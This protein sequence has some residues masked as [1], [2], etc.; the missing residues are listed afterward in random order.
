MAGGAFTYIMV[1][2]GEFPAWMTV[3]N[4][5]TE[6]LFGMAVVARSFSS[7]LADLCGKGPNYFRIG[8]TGSST[9][10][11]LDL[12]AMAIV[13]VVSLVFAA[14]GRQG[15]LFISIVSTVKLAVIVFILIVGWTKGDPSNL[16]PF[17]LEGANGIFSAASIFMYA[18]TGF[19]SITNAAEEARNVSSLPWAILGTT[20][21]ST[22]IYMLLA[23]MLCLMVPTSAISS[24]DGISQAFDYVGLHYMPYVVAT[25]AVMGCLTALLVGLYAVSRIIMVVARDWL[26][27]PVFARISARTQT[28]LVAQLTIGGIIALI[29]MLVQGEFLDELVSFGQ[30]FSMWAVVNAQMFRRYYPGIKLRFTRFGAVETMHAKAVSDF[31]P[32]ARLQIGVAARRKLAI[33]HMVLLSVWAFALAVWFVVTEQHGTRSMEVAGCVLFGCLLFLTALSMRLLCPI[34]YEPTQFHVPGILMPWVPTVAIGLIFFGMASI[35]PTGYYKIGVY[36]LAILAIY[37][38]FSLPMSYI[39]HYKLDFVQ[40]EQLKYVGLCVGICP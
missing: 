35:N 27:P 31:V 36:N 15:H 5:F 38:L 32:G 11:S 24:Q 22:I 9:G 28:P 3:A 1:V 29:T 34:Q 30:L 14:S 10:W 2:F 7:Y 16:R 12:M 4:Q 8:G 20:T 6:Y 26:L 23:L 19:D 39:K 18:M 17:F 21:L 40:T 13:V 37:F 25:A 33:L